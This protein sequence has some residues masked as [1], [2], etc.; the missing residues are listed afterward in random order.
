MSFRSVV[1]HSFLCAPM[2]KFLRFRLIDWIK[3]DGV[4]VI[5][6]HR[7]KRKLGGNLK[8]SMKIEIHKRRPLQNMDEIAL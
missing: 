7:Y 5:Q 1:I 4:P 3:N 8:I 6:G 2:L